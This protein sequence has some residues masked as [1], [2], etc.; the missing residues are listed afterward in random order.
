MANYNI[1]FSPT[2]G[3]K[4]VA[5]ILSNHL[6]RNFTNIDLCQSIASLSLSEDDVCIVSVPSFGGRVPAIAIERLQ[7]IV[8]NGAQ[9]VLNCVYGNREWEDTLTELQDTMETLGFRCIAAIAAVAEHSIFRQ[10]ATGRPDADDE[11]QLA[12]F[13]QQIQVKLHTHEMT[14]LQLPGNHGTYKVFNGTP[15][16]P[17]ANENC[18]GCGRCAKECP[19]GAI[20]A[21][22]PL[23]PDAEKCMSCMRCIRICPQQ[24]RSCDA[25]LMALL[26][27]KLTP[28]L[29]GHKENH[30]FL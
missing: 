6:L 9:A 8:G 3:T 1:Y 25:D 17:T 16:Q 28:V 19:V 29:N 2:G 21:N 7:Q 5:D 26:T 12:E 22:H 24:A 10:F 18:T 4:K 15:L 20:D 23:A 30:L 14:G 13:S 27:E 11:S